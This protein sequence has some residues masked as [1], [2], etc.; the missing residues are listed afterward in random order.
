M[1]SDEMVDLGLR[2][3][4]TWANPDSVIWFKSSLGSRVRFGSRVRSKSKSKDLHSFPIN[5]MWLSKID[6]SYSRFI[7]MGVNVGSGMLSKLGKDTR[8][9]IDS[10][11][12]TESQSCE[13]VSHA[14]SNS[15]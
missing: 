13:S 2:V 5:G 3:K 8:V 1:W 10:K 11:I 6:G 4:G 9:N 15:I 7:G 14:C 12:K